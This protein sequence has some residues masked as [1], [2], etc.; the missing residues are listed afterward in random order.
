[1]TAA[2]GWSGGGLGAVGGGIQEPVLV[3]QRV[4]GAGLGSSSVGPLV[5]QKQNKQKSDIWVK[6]QKRFQQAPVLEA[7]NNDDSEE[8]EKTV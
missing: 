1:M 4:Q 6:T 2:M 5:K 3:Q 8:E 7:F